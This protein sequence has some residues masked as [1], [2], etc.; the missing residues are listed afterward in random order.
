MT[1]KFVSVMIFVILVCSMSTKPVLG[2]TSNARIGLYYYVWYGEGLG[3]R[4]WNDSDNNVI[5]DK[6]LLGFYSSQN[7]AVIKQHLDWFKD[8]NINF[9]II[10]W[11]GKGSYEDDAT[12]TVFSIAKQYNY[13]IEIAI[14]VEA[15]NWSGIYDFKAIFD[16]INNTYVVPYGSIY[17]RLDDLPLVCFFNDDIN[18]TRTEENRTNIRSSAAGFSARIVGQSDYV[19][20]YAWPIAGYSEAPKPKLSRDGYLGILPRYDDTHLPNSTN[21]EYDVNY[22]EG[23]YDK[24]W[25]EVLRPENEGTV[26]Y[27]AIYS[28]NEYRERSQIEPHIRADDKYFLSPFSKTYHYIQVIPEFPSFL[29][30]SL[31]MI[32]MLLAV[33]VRK[34]KERS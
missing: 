28:W 13:P 20:W 9:L 3:S 27:V 29:I 22:T 2:S 26:K 16:Y 19:D 8:L 30:P 23:L 12:K 21:T 14:M 31:F 25:K 34:K 32:A 15:F 18:M 6:P 24:Q 1:A 7:A 11:W 5:V 10:S 4:H 33:T 17:M